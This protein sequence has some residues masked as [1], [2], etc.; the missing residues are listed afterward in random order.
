MLVAAGAVPA[1][2][3]G[4]RIPLSHRCLQWD[5]PQGG[6]GAGNN[7]KVGENSHRRGCSWPQGIHRRDSGSV[8]LW[9][10][11]VWTSTPMAWLW[12][13]DGHKQNSQL[14]QRV[15]GQFGDLPPA[16]IPLCTYSCPHTSWGSSSACPCHPPSSPFTPAVGSPFPVDSFPLALDGF[17]SR[18][19]CPTAS[20]RATDPTDDRAARGVPAAPG[21]ASIQEIFPKER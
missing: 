9:N 1:P 19:R 5:T 10:L 2:H 3:P 15:W 20:K 16:Q 11:Q 12:L 21:F 14:R 13:Q 7:P 18:P 4:T 17:G 8:C 6:R